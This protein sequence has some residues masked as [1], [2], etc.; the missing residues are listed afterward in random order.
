M[1]VAAFVWALVSS[2][3]WWAARHPAL[4]ESAYAR[5]VY[6]QVVRIMSFATGLLPFSV[7]EVLLGLG[8]VLF[9]MGI[10]RRIRM[11]RSNRITDGS[12]KLNET[13]RTSRS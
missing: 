5:L 7:A 1:A 4:T 10:V 6:P 3:R 13:A 11:R 8:F 9:G 12:L 2:S